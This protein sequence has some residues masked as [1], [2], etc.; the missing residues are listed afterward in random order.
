MVTNILTVE[1]A[2]VS[3]DGFHAIDHLNLTVRDGELRFLIGPNGAGKTTL[4]DMLSGKTR[5]VSGKVLFKG[6]IDVT[7]H[8]EHQLVRLG[9]GRKFQTP[10]V[11]ASLTCFENLEVANG[12]RG[13]IPGL[14]R[15]QSVYERDRIDGTLLTVGLAERRNTP[16]GILSHGERQWLEIAMLLIQSPRVLL[17]DEPVAGMT[18]KEREKTG[19]LL[20]ALQDTHTMIVTEHDME[21][22]RRFSQ[23]VTVM[24][25][26]KVIA[27]GSVDE[28]Q[29]NPEV[30]EVYLGRAREEAA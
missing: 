4:M 14:L 23:T 24:H 12:F 2:V 17:L 26:G 27:E 25:M 20:H 9:I 13:S 7:R 5:P 15:R 30:V 3:F 16:A 19:E 29:N 28:V 18:K 8:Q 10:S 21:F 22:V 11:Y 1:D 6:T